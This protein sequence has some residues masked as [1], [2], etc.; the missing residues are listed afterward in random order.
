MDRREFLRVAGL[1]GAGAWCAA[2]GVAAPA[3]RQQA[4]AVAAPVV[5]PQAPNVVIILADDLG[6]GDLGCYGNTE[7]ATPHID[8]LAAGGLRFTDFHSN[9]AVCSP[10]R[11]S[12]LTG[13]YPQRWGIEGVLTPKDHR[14]KPGLSPKAV[15]FAE[16]LQESGYATGMVG[17]WHLGYG[18]QYRPTHQGFAT[19]YGYLSGNVD[20]ESHIDNSGVYDWWENDKPLRE[21]GYTTTLI[22]KHAVNFIEGQGDAPFCLY[23]AHE[24]PHYP[25]QGP[26]DPPIRVEGTT[27]TD[28]HVPKDAAAVYRE[29][30]EALDDSVGQIVA[31]L[32]RGGHLNDTLIFFCS[33]NGAVSPG[34]NAPLSGQKGT[35]LEGGQRVPAIASW[36]GT[37]GP[38]VTNQTAITMDIF[39]TLAELGA[40]KAWSRIPSD[41]V[42]LVPL[43]TANKPLNDRTLFWRTQGKNPQKAVR[44]GAWKLL[45]TTDSTSLFDLD[46]DLPEQA[47]MMTALPSQANALAIALTNWEDSFVG[48]PPIA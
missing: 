20:Y 38:G 24:A 13:F 25:Y 30:V 32:D 22:T 34:S 14:D 7:I 39:P 29:M 9:G 11:A 45:I 35:L 1:S 27:D 15:T 2:S 6:Y 44:Q 28:R 33:D 10:T 41:G 19:F 21:K 37:I 47:N 4:P 17:K 23:V 3:G 5:R 43:L 16:M 36:P 42:S 40:R 26:N 8:A 48:I 31:A 12:L 18:E 46:S